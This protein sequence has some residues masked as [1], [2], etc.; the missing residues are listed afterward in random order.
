MSVVDLSIIIFVLME[1]ANIFILY[2]MPDSRLGNGVAIF[3]E[4]ENSKKDENT[5]LFAKYMANWVAGTK[6]IFIVLLL[7]ILF[8]GSE[9]TKVCAVLVMVLSIAT[10]F[11]K[12]HPIIKKLD[13][14]KKITPRGYSKALWFMIAGFM[15]MFSI[16]FIFGV[17]GLLTPAE[18]SEVAEMSRISNIVKIGEIL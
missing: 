13:K 17:I 1:T 11:F 15:V 6:L 2:Y 5:H 4:W 10:Y 7:V 9:L 18:L 14:A 3:D 16:A 12:L 8:T